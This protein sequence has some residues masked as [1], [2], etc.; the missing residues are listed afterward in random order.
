MK[1]GPEGAKVLRGWGKSGKIQNYC[2]AR[3]RVCTGSKPPSSEGAIRPWEMRG[4]APD[5][6][7]EL[8]FGAENIMREYDAGRFDIAVIGAGHPGPRRSRDALCA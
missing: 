1:W 5:D 2:E 6:M 3:E 8:G 4:N 7:Y